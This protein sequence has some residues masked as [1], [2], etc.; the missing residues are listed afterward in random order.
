[1]VRNGNF[2]NLLLP[3]KYSRKRKIPEFT[4]SVKNGNFGNFPSVSGSGKIRKLVF[5]RLRRN[6]GDGQGYRIPAACPQNGNRVSDNCGKS[7]KNWS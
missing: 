7:K 4:A 3:G 1:M 5:Y 6:S 2:R